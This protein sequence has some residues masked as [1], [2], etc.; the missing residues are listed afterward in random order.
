MEEREIN[1]MINKV[2]G[3]AS[4]AAKNYRIS[5]P[6]AW[7]TELGINPDNRKMKASFDGKKIVLELS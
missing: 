5:I 6:T 7:A 2:G 3:N 4:K 1:V